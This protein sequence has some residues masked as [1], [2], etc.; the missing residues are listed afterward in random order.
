MKPDFSFSVVA[1]MLFL[2]SGAVIA[3]GIKPPAS[4][5]L[6]K[7]NGRAISCLVSIVHTSQQGETD[8]VRLRFQPNN[9]NDKL[10]IC[11]IVAGECSRDPQSLSITSEDYVG[12]GRKQV[13]V[14]ATYGRTTSHL[15]DY[16]GETVHTLYKHD[17]GREEVKFILTRSGQWH[18][19][20]YWRYDQYLT[21]GED[22]LGTALVVY[23]PKGN[24][25]GKVVR[26]LH[27]D[28]NQFVPDLPG[29]SKIVRR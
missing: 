15:Y 4:I 13:F 27:W 21:S 17:E 5:P 1:V 26:M 20:E 24:T 29:P 25:S 9:S 16:D 19:A 3:D 8:E 2:C 14:S 12:L 7:V 18:L 22:D 6:G 28:G 23:L 11:E 10:K